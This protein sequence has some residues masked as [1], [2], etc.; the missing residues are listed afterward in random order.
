MHFYESMRTSAA[1]VAR[2]LTFVAISLIGPQLL[3]VCTPTVTAS[4]SGDKITATGSITASCSSRSITLL[5]DGQWIGDETC[6]FGSAPCTI[7]R[8]ITTY[9]KTAG[10]HTVSAVGTCYEVVNGSCRA[11]TQGSASTPVTIEGQPTVSIAGTNPDATGLVDGTLSYSLPRTRNEQGS[12]EWWVVSPN[13]VVSNYHHPL[14]E[15]PTGTTRIFFSTSCWAPG[16]YQIRARV[17]TCGGDVTE[18]STPLVVPSHKPTASVAL[19]TS[20]TRYAIVTW[21]FPHTSS[22]S[23]RHVRLE[24]KPDQTLIWETG[25][26]VEQNGTRRVLLPACLPEKRDMARVIAT[27]C[28]GGA[29]GYYEGPATLFVPACETSCSCETEEPSNPLAAL[30][31]SSITTS[32]PPSANC[33]GDP[34]RVT[35]GNMRLTDHDALPGSTVA[36]LRRVYDSLKPAGRFGPGWRTIFDAWLQATGGGIDVMIG[37]EGGDRLVFR[38]ENGSYRQVWPASQRAPGSL[39]YDTVAG[40]YLHRD[41]G[42]GIVRVFRGTRLVELRKVSNGDAVAITYDAAGLPVRVADTRDRW[43]WTV[44]TAADGKIQTISVDGRPDLV[45]TYVY[46]TVG[47][48]TSVTTAA[49]TWRTY[50]YGTGG[51]QTARDGAGRLMESH[52]YDATGRAITSVGDAGDITGFAYGQPGRIAGETKTRVTYASGRITDYYSRYIAGKMRTVQI[53]GSCDCGS[54]DAVYGYN[55]NGQLVR[56]QDAFGYI[57][58]RVFVDERVTQETSHLT[59]AGCDPETDAGHCRLTPDA[60]LTATLVPRAESQTVSYTYG[61]ANWPDRATSITTASVLQP[62]AS[63]TQQLT[64]APGTGA[65]LV[66]SMTGWTGTP[67]AEQ[68]RTSTATLYD[69]TEAAAFSPGGAFD[70]WAALPQPLSEVKATDG[71]RGDVSDVAT[72]VYYPIHTSVPALLRGRLAASRNA[73][74]HIT[75]YEDYDV[76]GN[77]LRTVDPNGVVTDYT[78]DSLGRLT[79]TTLRGVAGCDTTADPLCNTDITT[80]RRYDGTGPVAQEITTAGVTSYTYDDRGHIKTISR[81]PSATDLRE[82]IEYTYDPASGKKSIERTLA[83][84]NGAWVEK[85]RETYTYNS[86][87]DLTAVTYP[88]GKSVGYTYGA[89]SRLAS[90]RD[91]NHSQ[92][93]TFYKYDPASRIKEVSQTLATAAGGVITTQYGYDRDGNLTSV[94]D[95]N[96]NVTTYVYD[97]FGQMLRQVSPVT[98]TTTYSYDVG[99]NLLTT[100]DANG[101]TTTRMYDA[102]G[103]ARNATSTRNAQTES[104]IWTYDAPQA[105]GR[106]ATM[107]DPTGVTS[108]AYDRRGLLLVENKTVAGA[109]Y[110]TR[111]GY[112]ASGHRTRIT[113]PSG[114]IVDYTFD[115]AGRPYSATSGGSSIVNSATY[116]PFGPRTSITFGNGTVRQTPHDQRYRIQSNVL[117]SSTDVVANY[118]YTPDSSGNILAIQ[119]QLDHAYDRTFAYDD[120]HRLVTANSGAALWGSGSYSYDRMGN[121]QSLSL[122]TRTSTFSYQGTLPKLANVVENGTAR[123]V[124]Y[125]PAGNEIGTGA[126]TFNYSPR[127]HMAGKD[128]FSFGYDGRGIRT[129]STYPAHYLASLE[130]SRTVLYPN[131]AATGTVTLGA[132]APAG[133]ATV[134][135]TSSDSHVVVPPSVVVPAGATTALFGITQNGV[136]SAASV[137]VTASYGFTRTSIVAIGSAPALTSLTVSPTAFRGGAT[138]QA[139]ISLA[140]AAPSG[141]APVSISSS[142]SAASVPQTITIQEGATTASFNVTSVPVA[143]STDVVLTAAYTNSVTATLTITPAAIAAVVVTPSSIVGGRVAT[144][145]ITLDAPAPSGGAAVALVSSSSAVIVPSSVA[146][147]AA[148]TSTTFNVQTVAVTAT[149]SANVTATYH[150]SESALVNVTPCVPAVAAT[151]QMP[152]SD[153]VWIEDATPAGASIYSEMIWDDSQQASGSR[154]FTR[155]AI[156][157]EGRMAFNNVTEALPVAYGESL[158]FYALLNECSPPTSIRIVWVASDHHQ[159]STVWGQPVG[160]EQPVGPLPAPG[161]WARFVVPAR[162]LNMEYRSIKSI[163]LSQYNGQVWFDHIGVGAASCYPATAGTPTI[164]STDTMWVDDALPAGATPYGGTLWDTSQKASGSQAMTRR[165]QQGTAVAGFTNATERLALTWGDTLVF[166][167]LINE[168]V[169]PTRI[170]AL[171]YGAD[172]TTHGVAWGTPLSPY[173]HMGPIPAGGAWTRLAVSANLLNLEAK[174]VSGVWFQM[175]DGQAWFDAVGKGRNDCYPPSG[176]APPTIPSGDRVWIDDAKPAGATTYQEMIWDPSQKASGSLSFTRAAGTGERRMVFDNATETLPVAYGESLILYALLNECTPPSSIRVVWRASDGHQRSVVWGDPVGTEQ[177][178]G[179][180]PSPGTWARFSI[181]ARSLD[182]E[183]RSIATIQLSQYNGQA[184]FDHVGIGAAAC[185]PAT[186]AAPSIPSTD[187]IWAD[188]TLPAGAT[189]SGGTLWD[190]Q[191]KASGNQSMTRLPKAGSTIAGFT[192]ATERLSLTWGD[193]LVFQALVNEC[194]PPTRI[195]ALWFEGDGSMHGVAWGTPMSPYV[196]MGPIPSG[197]AWTRMAVPAKLFNLEAR[198]VSGVYFYVWDGQ[199]WFD[200]IGKGRSQCYPPPGIAPA[201]IPSSDRVWI[202]DA[203]PA[204]ASTFTSTAW[205]EARK[206]SGT[207]SFTTA[208]AAGAKQIVFRNGT[209]PLT[210]AHGESL[211]FYVLVNECAPPTSIRAMWRA[212]DGHQQTRIWGQPIG[213]EVPVGPLPA[214]GTWTRLEVPASA[215]GMEFRSIST[216][217]FTQY[218]GQAWFDRAGAGAAACYPAVAPAPSI[219]SADVVWADD[220]TPAGATMWPS[221]IWDAT[222]KAS[223]SQS[224]TRL[225]AAGESKLGFNNAT[226]TLPLASGDSVVFYALINQCAVPTRIMARWY[227]SDGQWHGASWGTPFASHV[228]MGPVPTGGAWTRMEVPAATLGMT[229]KTV[230]GVEFYVYDGQAWF[231]RV[232]KSAPPPPLALRT[233]LR[234]RLASWFS[235]RVPVSMGVSVGELATTSSSTDVRKVSLYTP[236]LQLMAEVEHVGNA[237][238]QSAH[239]YIWFAGEP[240]AQIDS[241][242]STVHW[243]FNDHLGTPILQTDAAANVV[244]RAEYTPYGEVYEFHTGAGK[245]QPLRFPGQENDGTSELSYNVFRWY[246]SGWGWYSQADPLLRFSTRS[247]LHLDFAY[248]LLNPA[249]RIDPLGLFTVSGTCK[250]CEGLDPKAKDLSTYIIAETSAWCKTKLGAIANVTLQKCIADRCANGIVKC[251]GGCEPGLYGKAP[252]AFAGKFGEWLA[253]NIYSPKTAVVCL[254]AEGNYLGEAGNTVIHEWAHGCGCDSDIPGNCKGIPGLPSGMPKKVKP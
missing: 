224:M 19:D 245:H 166:Q 158:I 5:F 126:E 182:M 246:R 184:W 136:S 236:E 50:T 248:A 201:T 9:C 115:F 140:G 4:I 151:P 74:G 145:T 34:V 52:Q 80:E 247:E 97:D 249:R 159:G 225:P 183:F 220:G 116:L 149:A 59:P 148:A 146:V 38:R 164:P 188:D 46:D 219:P 45:W 76:F 161:T 73:A 117:S 20:D 29:D 229:A 137:T 253:K 152:S 100:T 240:V 3:A 181:P 56:Q 11:G 207:R 123:G 209:S 210:V 197:G 244:W 179:P 93:N 68:T 60:L 143:T 187:V 162:S 221:T 205:D 13:N 102:L 218:D 194:A 75:R 81:G 174:S 227:T 157:G 190:T 130:I 39:V 44:T 175:W 212:T 30:L 10:N 215:V 107:S 222:Q 57:V 204:G 202:E 14:I 89:A 122:G 127:N 173:V 211:A 142:H 43:A 223:G 82:R 121:L 71:P 238:P 235:P 67:A 7:T 180:L 95:P 41:P 22:S 2:L 70:A 232:G 150:G 18:T 28:G 63:K 241:A 230:V 176:V 87:E 196:H 23:D 167:T 69:G 177:P 168:C 48:L 135:L 49:G 16:T 66:A 92:P 129:V 134:E 109:T 37:T 160:T 58:E 147:P 98:G 103:R 40:E 128:G 31:F 99:G 233:S 133:G 214:P 217:E 234:D 154:S 12:V 26:D 228:D 156:T 192:N 139:T 55:N 17:K 165:P 35:S 237:A 77:A 206:V 138:A 90:V 198:S 119:D 213:S 172:G 199:A 72:L 171:W 193:T 155:P 195:V 251:E 61:D 113:Y 111:Y 42:Q 86:L 243:Y 32:A 186:A 200:A 47:R 1:H 124:S 132:A 64:Y 191:Q 108:Y 178:T 216:M 163:Q 153:R 254:N 118:A 239:E 105:L 104:V 141:G 15:T 131:Q 21:A 79:F 62:G 78:Y 53:D 33:A 242:T 114:R 106:L 54:E 6:G 185:Y 203:A 65:I 110:T 27:A 112:D 125:D 96:G 101:A 169:P 85:K 25:R 170:V 84:E 83:F 24:W 8:E 51:L 144:G 88:D 91:E 94:T 226:A 36:P 120:L 231:D 252:G 189:L 250:K 208:A